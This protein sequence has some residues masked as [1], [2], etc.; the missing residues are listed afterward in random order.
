MG[1]EDNKLFFVG[2]KAFIEKE[3]SL[4][5]VRESGSFR[6]GGNWELPGGRIQQGET[7]TPFN[8]VLLREVKEECGAIQIIVGDVIEIF[9]R[10]FANGQWVVLAGFDCRYLS[11]EVTV[12]DEHSEYAWI[13][14][15]DLPSYQFVPGYK[16]AIESY[17][18]KK[19]LG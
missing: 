1:E 9:R 3:G 13:T 6:E 18:K 14:A 8:E 5:V 15:K 11:G 17:F 4:L 19:L 16:E 7:E 12:S 10:K 2:L